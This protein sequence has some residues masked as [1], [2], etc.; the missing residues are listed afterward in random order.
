L[1]PDR[2]ARGNE[3]DSA[4]VEDIAKSLRERLRTVR[5]AT[6]TLDGLLDATSDLLLGVARLRELGKKLGPSDRSQ[7]EEG[8]SRLHGSA[9]ELHGQVVKAR[10]TPLTILTDRLPQHVRQ[11]TR[12]IGREVDLRVTGAELELDRSIIDGLADVLLHLLRNCIDHGIE[13]ARERVASGK[14]EVGTVTVDARR[15]QDQ[16]VLEVADDGRGFDL[17]A[18]RLAAVRAGRVDLRA[19]LAL[20]EAEVLM[21]AC[22]PGITTAPSVTDVSGRGVGLD[23]VKATVEGLSGTFAIESQL[24]LGTRFKMVM[25]LLV[26]LIKVLLVEVDREIVAL[27]MGRV[28]AAVELAKGEP[29]KGIEHA[30]GFAPLHALSALLG[31]SE[32]PP[33]HGLALIWQLQD[34]GQ[35]VALQIDRLVGQ[36]EAVV[37]SVSPPLDRMPGISA[38]T[39]LGNGQPAF[40]LD[41][42][43]LLAA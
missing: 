30:Q 29:L 16:L 26:A 25:P 37:K 20:P 36:L 32:R 28:I 40:I 21:L 9:L 2:Q 19:A 3:A 35:T 34:G 39:L 7:L 11:L 43:R 24:G 12:R 10:L 1:I 13:P 23:V 42:P 6:D 22:L 17:N 14:P 31:W 5:V 41:V 8:V 38:V 15:E 18:L 27:P 33:D 4:M